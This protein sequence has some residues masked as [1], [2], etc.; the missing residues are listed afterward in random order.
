MKKIQERKE[1]E[2]LAAEQQ[3]QVQPATN[4]FPRPVAVPSEPGAFDDLIPE[5]EKSSEQDYVDRVTEETLQGVSVVDAYVRLIHK[6]IPK[7]APGQR[8]SIMISCPRPDHV[9]ANPSAWINL[10]KGVW[11]CAKCDD[12]GDKLS[13]GAISYGLTNSPRTDDSWQS[14]KTFPDLKRRM[15]ED[16]GANLTPPPPEMPP[17]KVEPESFVPTPTPVALPTQGTD[18]EAVVEPQEEPEQTES[19]SSFIDNGFPSVDWRAIAAPNTFLRTWMEILSQ[20]ELTEEYH[21]WHGMIAL[22]LAV[23]RDVHLIDA[24]PVYANLFVCLL[25]RTGDGKSRA[26]SY[27]DRA[28]SYA[29]P[30]DY[31][32]N[33]KSKGVKFIPS[34][35]SGEVLVK[36]FDNPIEDVTATPV[37]GARPKI[38]DHAPVRG[39]IDVSEMKTIVSKMNRSGNTMGPMFIDFYDCRSI[40]SDA[41]LST[42]EKM[43]KDAFASVISTTQPEALS[44]LLTD[45]NESSGWLNRWLFVGGPKKPQS[46]FGAFHPDV[47]PAAE[48]LK[49]IHV[50][51]Q[52]P[53]T[54]NVSM[55]P[56]AA[57]KANRDYLDWMEDLMA[58]D[59]TGALAR[60][61]LIIKKLCLLL[62][63]N[64][65]STIVTEAIYDKVILL[66]PYI[67][68]FFHVRIEKM[69]EHAI[70]TTEQKIIEDLKVL[71]EAGGNKPVPLR[72]LR[73]K[74]G[75]KVPDIRTLTA[76]LKDLEA[77]GFVWLGEEKS[78]T[79]GPATKLVGYLGGAE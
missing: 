44:D 51:S 72:D 59:A 69:Q 20:D 42:G 40:I 23:G 32:P 17:I 4:G 74:L 13:L 5:S 76:R 24:P 14:G 37:K 77:L 10:D 58:N 49:N 34:P 26:K 70:D 15:A 75:R 38:I 8:E 35:S 54:G 55:H 43:A 3:Q 16:F 28:L 33:A 68:S 56:D 22:G 73:R 63:I 71:Q 65:K 57:A 52:L 45:E 66:I 48:M 12:G 18:P 9:D 25:G 31:T 21:F 64:E 27:L 60:L 6:M 79:T 67:I 2:R 62:A 53:M 1:R 29:M 30:Y 41:S 50:W 36:M 39:L 19:A 78:K 7:I 47:T 61:P 46:M 11:Y